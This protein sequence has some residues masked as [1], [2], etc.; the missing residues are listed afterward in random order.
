MALQGNSQNQQPHFQPNS[1]SLYVGDLQPDVTEAL[2]FEV[3]SLAGPVA[4]IRVCRDSITRRSLGYA[5]VNFHSASEAE[6]ALDILNFYPI[7]GVPCRVMWSSRDPSIRKN[8]AG[9]LFI[10]NLPQNIDNKNL[11]DKF[12]PFGSILSC[13]VAVDSAGKS[14][15]FGFVH[16]A[17]HE[18]AM[19]AI[20]T[21]NDQLVDG[22]KVYVGPFE[23]R[24]ERTGGKYTNV[25]V[26]NVPKSWNKD[27]FESIFQKFG[28]ITS[29]CLPTENDEHKGFGFV[30]YEKHEEALEA[31][32]QGKNIPT[33]ESSPLY[34]DRFQKKT[35]RKLT[36][37]RLSVNIRRERAE[38]TKNLNLYVKN[39]EDDVDDERLKEMFSEFG[40][41]N[42]AV[43]MRSNGISRGFGFVCFENEAEAEKALQQMRMK[44]VGKKPLYVARA[45]GKEE[46]R[47]QLENEFQTSMVQR[48]QYSQLFYPPVPVQ[49]GVYY[50]A[51]QYYGRP[52]MQPTLQMRPMYQQAASAP[53][54]PYMNTQQVRRGNPAVTAT[55][56]GGARNN[57]MTQ[58]QVV[59]QNRGAGAPRGRGMPPRNHQPPVTPAPIVPQSFAS[60]QDLATILASEAPERQKN[61]L[62]ERLFP[63]I[64]K[65]HPQLAGKITGMLL[66]MEVSEILQLLESEKD[67][68][69]KIREA[70]EVLNYAK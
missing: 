11:Y 63:L 26:K 14:R 61:I 25:Y 62:G 65:G 19:S 7:K 4:S 16:F 31:V 29:V 9:N 54:S 45:Q 23:R 47:I 32:N 51:N 17:S 46:R 5:Y 66:E 53:V 37:E 20:N 44:Q 6:K 15:G 57:Y 27:K 38:K 28:T 42:S 10:K 13:K 67:R 69:A 34:V 43:V 58:A 48:M 1:T 68:E 33:G 64:H 59:P 12:S 50:T 18:S 21:L 52:R 35:E 30:N 70:L 39:L 41:V 55:A 22:T 24:Q 60:H 2:L 56:V 3:F 40:K 36:L 8:P 49:Q